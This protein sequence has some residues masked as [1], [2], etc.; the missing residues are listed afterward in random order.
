MFSTVS[1]TFPRDDRIR[2][3][4]RIFGSGVLHVAP[5]FG[6]WSIFERDRRIRSKEPGRYKMAFMLAT[7]DRDIRGFRNDFRKGH[8]SDAT[9]CGTPESMPSAFLCLWSRHLLST[10]NI[11]WYKKE[12]EVCNLFV[13]PK[14]VMSYSESKFEKH[15]HRTHSAMF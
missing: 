12:Q 9:Y 2:C 1:I 5:K 13:M 6:F 15:S 7:R 4:D 3:C 8:A 11:F 10:G 14:Q